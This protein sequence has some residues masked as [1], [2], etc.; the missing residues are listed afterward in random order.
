MLTAQSDAVYH[1]TIVGYAIRQR[2]LGAIVADTKVALREKR[3][4][5]ARDVECFQGFADYALAIAVRV[6]VGLQD[7]LI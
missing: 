4:V 3:D 7:A 2:Q 5:L 1:R 6:E